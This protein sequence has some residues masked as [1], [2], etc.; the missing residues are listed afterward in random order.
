MKIRIA[1]DVQLNYLDI[2]SSFPSP[3]PLET[4]SLNLFECSFNGDE[5]EV[6][7]ILMERSVCV[8][9]CDCHGL[10]SLHFA[11]YNTHIK[12]INTLLDFGANVNQLNDDGLTALSLAFLLYY[13]NNPQQTR[14]LALEHLDPIVLNPRSTTTTES[15]SLFLSRQNFVHSSSFLT[16]DSAFPDEIKLPSSSVFSQLSDFQSKTSYGFRLTNHLQDRIR[17]EKFRQKIFSVIS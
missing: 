13:G 2:R 7:N 8:D 4:A 11:V 6:R 10:T 5:N 15:N 9:V 3:G 17:D 14:N 1:I 12:V 16:T